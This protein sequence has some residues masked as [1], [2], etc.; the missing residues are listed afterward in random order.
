MG[1]EQ[2]SS[3]GDMVASLHSSHPSRFL[4]LFPL[5][6]HLLS[7]E[8]LSARVSFLEELVHV[9]YDDNAMF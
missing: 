3:P 7:T 2:S 9:P 4:F 6:P 5:V 8:L 1:W